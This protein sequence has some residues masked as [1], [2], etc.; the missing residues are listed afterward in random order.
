MLQVCFSVFCIGQHRRS[1]SCAQVKDMLHIQSCMFTISN[2]RPYKITINPLA[3][4][5][6][7][8][9]AARC[10]PKM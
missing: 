3:F 8:T 6:A 7:Q 1:V 5:G 9:I 10:I 4:S 2:H